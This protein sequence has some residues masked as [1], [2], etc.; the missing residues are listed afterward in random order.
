MLHEGD[1]LPA[2]DTMLRRKRVEPANGVEVIVK[3]DT[4]TRKLDIF[5][6]WLALWLGSTLRLD[7]VPQRM[8]ALL[9]DVGPPKLGAFY[10]IELER[11]HV[12]SAGD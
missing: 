12:L 5:R 10:K 9:E 3:I 11:L 1:T 7:C 8:Q 6:A 4:S 2:W